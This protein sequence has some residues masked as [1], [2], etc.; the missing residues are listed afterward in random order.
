M[1]P[2]MWMAKAEK[3][4]SSAELLLK[5]G[6]PDAACNRSYYAMFNAARASLLIVGQGEKAMSKTHST[7]I[8][9]FGQYIAKTGFV[10]LEM[11]RIFSHEFQ[12]RLFSDYEGGEITVIEAKDSIDNA[13]KFIAAVKQWIS[14]QQ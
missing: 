3:C 9:A 4:L 5:N 10:P 7:I 1:N 11:G 13:T 14:T 2:E 8:G 6:D 12:R